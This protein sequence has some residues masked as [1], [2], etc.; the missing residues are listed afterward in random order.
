MHR[1]PLSIIQP[2]ESSAVWQGLLDQSMWPE[3][4]LPVGWQERKPAAVVNLD[5]STTVKQARMPCRAG[6][7]CPLGAWIGRHSPRG[8][9]RS[10]CP[11]ARNSQLPSNWIRNQQDR[12]KY[13]RY[14]MI[15]HWE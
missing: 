9:E 12:P 11:C 5:G 10:C 13:V 1:R 2:C 4:P 6:T 3:D 7:P 8:I 15:S 14:S